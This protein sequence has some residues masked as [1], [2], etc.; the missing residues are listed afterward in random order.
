VS[1]WQVVLIGSGYVQW[2]GYGM[3]GT[4]VLFVSV[5]SMLRPC[6]HMVAGCETGIDSVIVIGIYE[7]IF[8]EIELVCGFLAR[9]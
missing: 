8:Q 3:P 5:D 1:V 6:R 7:Y 9:I 4:V 2:P